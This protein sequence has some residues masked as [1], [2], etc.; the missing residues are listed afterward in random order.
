MKVKKFKEKELIVC[1]ICL[2]LLILSIILFNIKGLITLP[3]L[4]SFVLVFWNRR[5]LLRKINKLK[6]KK[7]K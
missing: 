1:I 2:I 5:K 4:I 7:N 6:N 3:F